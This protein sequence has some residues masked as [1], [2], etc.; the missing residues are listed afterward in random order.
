[1][2]QRCPGK[3]CFGFN[4]VEVLPVL[5]V[6]AVLVVR[7]AGLITESVEEVVAALFIAGKAGKLS[8]GCID[9]VSCLAFASI[10]LLQDI[11]ADD[12]RPNAS[13]FLSCI[14]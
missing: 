9:V 14:V 7:T 2:S 1:M 10:P 12:R 3:P 13:M 8:A 6:A 11:I 4:A 5:V